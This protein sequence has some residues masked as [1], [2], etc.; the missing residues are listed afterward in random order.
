MKKTILALTAL[1][2]F[3]TMP[4]TAMAQSSGKTISKVGSS[5]PSG[6]SSS[7]SKC[8]SQGDAVAVHK[9]GGSSCPS[10]FTS[11]GGNKYC[12]STK[13]GQK[14]RLKGSSSCPSGYESSGSNKYCIK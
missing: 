5:C 3:A 8:V 11:S 4:H 1:A 12:V 7:S 2:A 14:V 10:G 6:F 9:V 13:S